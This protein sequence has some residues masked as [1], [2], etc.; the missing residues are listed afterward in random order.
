MIIL[1]AGFIILSAAAY[2]S[3]QNSR[4]QTWLI[5]F[6]TTELQKKTNSKVSVSHIDFS[7]FNKLVL[8]NVFIGDVNNDT[9]FYSKKVSAKIS[10]VDFKNKYISLEELVLNENNI[11]LDK[12]SV[13]GYN[14]K[15]LSGVLSQDTKKTKS[16]NWNF[17]CLSFGFNNATISYN[18][19]EKS[20]DKKLCF[21]NLH[22]NV[23]PLTIIGDT[24]RFNIRNLTFDDGKSFVL[25]KLNADFMAAGN[26][27]SLN[28]LD[29]ATEKSNISNASFTFTKDTAARSI[30]DASKIDLRLTSSRIN[31]KEIS[32][33]VPELKGMEQE[34]SLT[35]HIYGSMGDLKGK[36]I[37]LKTGENTTMIVDFYANDLLY[38]E[39]MYLFIDLNNSQTTF[40]DI[41]NIRLP[42]IAK[43]SYIK[44]PES[45][46]KTGILN[47]NG[48]F[49]GF[50]SDFVA[51]GTFSSRMGILKTDLAV[52]PDK[53]GN[54][55]YKGKV[56]TEGFKLGELFQIKSIGAVSF[57]GNLNG[58]YS[59]LKKTVDGTMN[60][61]VSLIEI[62][63]YEY[64][65]IALNGKFDNRNFNGIINIADPNLDLSFTGNVN[66]NL[67]AP[68]FDFDM[69]VNK[70]APEKLGLGKSFETI[71]MGFNLH[72][73]FTGKKFNDLNGSVIVDNG[74][75]YNKNGNFSF[76]NIKLTADQ[77]NQ[78]KTVVLKSP[79]VD[80]SMKGRYDFTDILN[81]VSQIIS[82]YIPNLNF[83]TE[84]PA[85]ENNFVY[86]VNIK[87]LETILPV[88]LPGIEVQTPF[89]LYGKF[90]DHTSDFELEGSIP[91]LKTTAFELR[92]IFISNKPKEDF[93]S[94]KIRIGELKAYKN[95]SLFNL[96]MESTVKNSMLK[97]EISWDNNSNPAHRGKISSVSRFQP[98][99]N[100]KTPAF[101]TTFEKGDIVIA[102]NPWH[103]NSFSTAVDSTGINV[104]GLRI[105]NKQQEIAVDGGISKNQSKLLTIKLNDI[106]IDHIGS[107]FMSKP[108][109][110]GS[111]SGYVGL[112]DLFGQKK[113]FTDIKV[114]DFTYKKQNFGDILLINEWNNAEANINTHLT[115]SQK[116]NKT[117]V[118]SGTYKPQTDELNY[119]A[120]FNKTSVSFLE[121]FMQDIFSGIHGEATGKI[122]LT[123]KTDNINTD[124]S[125]FVS[126]GG[127]TVDYTKVSYQFSDSVRFSKNSILFNKIQLTDNARN[128]AVFD[129]SIRHN[130]LSNM[131]YNL[132]LTSPKVMVFNTTVSDNDLF[133]GQLVVG[134]NIKITGVDNK[135]NMSGNGTTL[136]GTN[137]NISLEYESDIK[138]ND[139][140]EFVP[141]RDT[142]RTVTKQTPKDDSELTLNFTIN[143]RPE[144]RAQLIY[145]S[146]IG[147]VIKAQGEG[148]LIFGMDKDENISL[149]GNY[150]ISKGDYLF[151]LQNVINKHFTIEPGSMLEWSGDPFNA[152]INIAAVY[153]L[154]TSLYDLFLDTYSNVYQN[155]N[156]NQRIPVD[157][158]IILTE[159]LLS[160]AID[161]KIDF[162]TVKSNIVEELQQFF[163]TKEDINKQMLS[164]LV[165]GKFYTPEYLRGNFESQNPNILGTTAKTASELLSNQL[166][167][168][169]SQ[170][171]QNFDVGI[172]YTLGNQ[173]TNDEIE[174]A[175]S[176]QMFND[177]VTINGNIANNANP[178]S[179]NNSSIV[180]DF[181][182]N[183]KLNKSGKIQL[184]AYNRS[185]NN[186]LYETAPYTQGIGLSFRE[187]HNTINELF[188]KLTTIFRKK[189][190]RN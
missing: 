172:N 79:F 66:L 36:N 38:P 140:I 183:V 76:N 55:S 22:L 177:R 117:L 72:A 34:I 94:S 134:G 153:K 144:A 125:V 139:F 16:K 130:N 57:N 86:E 96:D 7:F 5:S 13:R 113:I 157:C 155:V 25:K 162:P 70:I 107:Y 37:I 51:F 63:N 65:N 80:A 102:D 29:L 52:I 109:L 90:N 151:T 145:N 133:Y 178:N 174:L 18:D 111:I 163:S 184:K 114:K 85:G 46:Y 142:I 91:F 6:L 10:A 164:L 135:I 137:M 73:N 3:L 67:K 173:V 167:N 126:D 190:E 1:V 176:T 95:F 47:Y 101:E 87:K 123:G 59:R 143:A 14:F 53:K 28:Y 26:Y 179:T 92:N 105:T 15:N 78:E 54:I 159:N 27:L 50:L 160:P 24:I 44:F 119:T 127:L 2:F 45:F 104:N 118:A 62:N 150:V 181:E 149:S 20:V 136:L 43:S 48:N 83:K 19:Q 61:N 132:S 32:S 84:T 138:D 128:K 93:Y 124:G 154:K 40:T 180:G 64:K 122:K 77:S 185:N 112:L 98:Y 58:N 8:E 60:G 186:L 88:L 115:V 41:S 166:S 129:G 31:L 35:G 97:N 156:Q 42:D 89:M 158:K 120:E 152:E 23:S 175:L 33:F 39:K 108:E 187:D 171:N 146:K 141:P 148:T 110:D 74:V 11:K 116:N 81:S 99:A 182:L 82:R 131:V 49:T 103:F 165:M 106:Q 12:D 188:R 189:T 147:D 30:A 100:I 56:K 4:V 17:R 21:K 68:V 169:F 170:I 168:W 161:F 69:K 121:I 75:F 9:L 71:E